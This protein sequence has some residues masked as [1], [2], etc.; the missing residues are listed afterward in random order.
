MNDIRQNDKAVILNIKY[1]PVIIYN[2]VKALFHCWTSF[3]HGTETF[4]IV[5]IE[6][7][8]IQ[9]IPPHLIRF[10]DG[11]DFEA[12]DW[13]VQGDM[14]ENPHDYIYEDAVD[15]ILERTGLDPSIITNVLDTELD[16]MRSIGVAYELEE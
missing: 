13:T 12:Y 5:E 4:A 9:V 2:N 3:G 10:I 16:Y 1:R 14:S 8:Y 15:Y 7:G 11:G 6:S